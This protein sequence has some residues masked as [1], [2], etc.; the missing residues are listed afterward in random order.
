MNC[1]RQEQMGAK[2]FVKMMK[3][4]QNL[5]ER[6]VPA[7]EAKHWRIEGEKKII[8]R[9]EYQRILNKFEME[10]SMAQKKVCGIWQRRKS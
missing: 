6:R 7:K 5:E 2:L 10:A 9:K 3:G 1:C 8:A 4:I